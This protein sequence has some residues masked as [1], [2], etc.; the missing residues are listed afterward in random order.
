MIFVVFF[1]HTSDNFV[2]FLADIRS[3]HKTRH[4]VIK[5]ISNNWHR[6]HIPSSWPQ[7]A[8]LTP[9]DLTKLINKEQEED[10]ATVIM[11][12]EPHSMLGREV[13]F[14]MLSNTIK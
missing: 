8:P 6:G 14:N 13:C 12:E 1:V 3:S 7:F 2:I 4:S 10:V 9:T 11:L 5:A